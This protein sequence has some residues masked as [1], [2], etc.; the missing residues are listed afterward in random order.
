MEHRVPAGH[1]FGGKFHFGTVAHLPLLVS[2]SDDGTWLAG[3]AWLAVA[4]AM[5][6]FWLTK[7]A[8]AAATTA[9]L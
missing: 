3:L 2:I 1:V 5:V 9:Q 7:P 6:H 4:I 8:P